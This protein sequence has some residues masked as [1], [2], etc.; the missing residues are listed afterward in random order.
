MAADTVSAELFSQQLPS[1]LEAEQS[2]LGSVLIDPACIGDVLEILRP[3]YFSRETHRRIFSTMCAMF[4]VGGTIDII[5]VMDACVKDGVFSSREDAKTY[6]AS[7]AEIVPSTANVE[8]Y[9]RIVR[10]KFYLRSLIEASREIV[11]SASE[12]K[13]DASELLELAEQK[14]Y[15]IREGRDSGSLAPI[16]KVVVETFDRLQKISGPNRA[17]YL[18]LSTGYKYLDAITT[19]L[20]KTDL[21]LIAGRPGMGKTAFGLNIV[22]NVA[23]GQGKPVAVFSLEM[24]K[25]QLVSRILSAEARVESQKLRMGNLQQE[26]W[27][28]LAEAADRLGRAPIWLDDTASITVP[29]MKAKLRRIRGLGLVMVD[30][31]QLMSTGRGGDNRVQEVSEITRSLKILA[32]ELNIPVILISQLSRK[33]EDRQDK[34]PVLSDLRDSGSI[35]QDAD[36]VMFLYR[37]IYYDRDNADQN[38]AQCLVAKNRHGET[39]KVDLYWDGRFTRFY[40]V[41]KEHDDEQG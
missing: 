4:A 36:L 19:G 35:E 21:I 8:A 13:A 22:T 1:S 40:S 30:Y 15:D 38:S 12:P 32:K 2:V 3:E 25:G 17:D 37:D 29:E 28:A 14:I 31:L 18:G 26:D 9:A 16:N 10:E 7:I 6:L 23:L 33:T 20:N 34:R 11:D 41:E 5:T 27:R 39:N 24:S